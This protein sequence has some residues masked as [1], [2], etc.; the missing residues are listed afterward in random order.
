MLSAGYLEVRGA[1][2]MTLSSER[3]EGPYAPWDTPYVQWTQAQ[4]SMTVRDATGTG[5]GWAGL[6]GDDWTAI[7]SAALAQRALE[8]CLAS[9]HPVAIEPGRYTLILEPQAVAGLLEVLVATMLRDEAESLSSN[10]PW[11]LGYD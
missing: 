8:K 11:K 6:S 1:S 10:S 4:C 3:P 2:H 5:S 7:D 9:Q